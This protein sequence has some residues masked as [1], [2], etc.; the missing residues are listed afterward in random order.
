VIANLIDIVSKNGNLLLYIDQRSD[1]TITEEETET[2]LRT[3][4]WL[5]VN[6]ESI[7]GTRLWKVYGEV[8][9]ESAS[10][11]FADQKIPFNSKDLRFSKK[12]ESV[13]ALAL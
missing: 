7:Y 12:G 1:G 5:D 11:L 2:L 6:G 13:Y 10:G 4:K 3:G 9:T 8:A